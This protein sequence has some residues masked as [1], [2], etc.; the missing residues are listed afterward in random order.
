MRNALLLVN[1]GCQ[2]AVMGALVDP[3]PSIEIISTD[4]DASNVMLGAVAA[5]VVS[6]M[7]LVTMLNKIGADGGGKSIDE[8]AESTGSELEL[9]DRSA[10]YHAAL[11]I[12]HAP[13]AGGGCLSWFRRRSGQGRPHPRPITTDD[14]HAAATAALLAGKRVVSTAAAAAAVAAAA[15]PANSIRSVADDLA[16][17][18]GGP[19]ALVKRHDHHAEAMPVVD[20]LAP[21]FPPSAPTLRQLVRALGMHEPDLRDRVSLLVCMHRYLATCAA[22]L[23][24]DPASAV[25]T[26]AVPTGKT[27]SRG[28][29][30]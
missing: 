2:T 1:V 20:A 22:D 14:D 24:E 23:P 8:N 9:G 12:S 13:K 4:D 25:G 5:L 18:G 11:A 17:L 27:P 29:L 15:E 3:G 19:R 16:P 6:T 30:S 7:L 28:R 21:T 10:S 26:F